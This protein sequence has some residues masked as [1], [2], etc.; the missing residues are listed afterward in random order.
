MKVKDIM[1]KV[2]DY[3]T[4][5]NKI[6]KSI[7]RLSK[8]ESDFEIPLKLMQAKIKLLM[9]ERDK[10]LNEEVLVGRSISDMR[11]SYENAHLWDK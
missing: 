11:S 8:E 10:F 5:I 9:S 3:Q 4:E 7:S 2:E 6:E 1:T